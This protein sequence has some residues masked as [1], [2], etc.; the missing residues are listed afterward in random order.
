MLKPIKLLLNLKKKH[1]PKM[2]LNDLSNIEYLMSEEG[3][4]ELAKAMA[5]PICRNLD[6]AKIAAA[7]FSHRYYYLYG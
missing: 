7:F 4:V 1:K 6:Y 2:L 3:Q 5:V